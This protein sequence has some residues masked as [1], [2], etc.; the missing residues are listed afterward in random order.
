MQDS[1]KLII[2]SSI[3]YAYRA[4]DYL[5][6]HGIRAYVERIPEH[7]RKTGCGYGVRVNVRADEAAG[8]LRDA[9]IPVRS[10][11]DLGVGSGGY[12]YGNSPY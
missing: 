2:L 6:R 4:R 8:L 7:L 11:L 1:R 12:T 10:I 5:A 3:T 9:G